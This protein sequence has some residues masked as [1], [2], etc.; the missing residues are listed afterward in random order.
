MNHDT[1]STNTGFL[2]NL[3]KSIQGLVSP[4]K[5]E[6]EVGVEVKT[7]ARVELKEPFKES[8][9]VGDDELSEAAE[10]EPKIEAFVAPR[11]ALPEGYIYPD[12]EEAARLHTELLRELPADHPLFGVPLETFAAR[13]GNDDTLFRYRGNPRR[14]VL[15]HLTG[16]GRT[17]I[18]ESHPKIVFYGTFEEF[19]EREKS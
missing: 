19:V 8:V 10:T 12:S 18:N 17:E 1:D 11:P 9:A 3:R 16:L 4:S 2:A 7:P 5:P 15:V 14:F 13:E 6:P